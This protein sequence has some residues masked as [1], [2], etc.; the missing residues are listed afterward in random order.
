MGMGGHFFDWFM[1]AIKT[2]T[3]ILSIIRTR[4]NN[5]KS[6]IKQSLLSQ[7]SHLGDFYVIRGFSSSVEKLTAY[8][9]LI[10]PCHIL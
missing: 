6:L 1:Y 4:D 8:R 5:S 3:K 9:L 2:V 10:V 7:I